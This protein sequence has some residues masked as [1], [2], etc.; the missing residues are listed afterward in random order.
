[1]MTADNARHARLEMLLA[2]LLDWGTWG[3][4]FVIGLGLLAVISGDH[5]TQGF[6][7]SLIACGIALFIV[8]PILRVLLMAIVFLTEKD[9]VFGAISICV[10]LIIALG[11]SIGLEYAQAVL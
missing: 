10:L 4:C 9:Y 8:L 11:A 3:A 2:K 5:T 7:P 1:M 6:G